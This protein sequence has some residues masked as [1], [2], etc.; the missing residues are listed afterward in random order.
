[1]HKIKE[2]ILSAFAWFLALLAFFC[3]GATLLV[4]GL[5]HTGKVF[6]WV[7]KITC[8]WVVYSAGMRL[9]ITG[10]EN[11]DP[12]KQYIIMMNHVN[13]LDPFVFYVGYP[14]KARGV[15]EE[16]HFNW[17]FYGWL[18]RR[19]GQIPINRKDG[20]KAIIALKKAGE[21]IRQN[22]NVSITILP[23][24][25][26]TLTGKLGQFKK[27]GFL[28]ALEAGIDILP[29][30]QIGAYQFKRK[31]SWLLRPGIVEVVIEKPIATSQYSRKNIDELIQETRNVFLKYV[32]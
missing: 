15:E 25:T 14:G 9:K 24:G 3:G 18:I 22:K 1:M 12:Q 10:L 8:R 28:I 17:P 5:F 21:L 26:R 31:G 30:I 32:D 19:I 4:I 13:S 7:L 16:S 29:M 23:E 2:N 20:R 6:E 11:I 27:G